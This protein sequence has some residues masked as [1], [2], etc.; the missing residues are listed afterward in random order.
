[1]VALVFVL[2]PTLLAFSPVTV[3]APSGLTCVLVEL[4]KGLEQAAAGAAF[5]SFFIHVA[6]LLWLLQS[7]E[8]R[9]ALQP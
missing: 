8:Q 5:F 9:Q 6:F 1:M 4:V 7:T 2:V 3:H